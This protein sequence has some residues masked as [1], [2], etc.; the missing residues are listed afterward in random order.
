VVVQ[1]DKPIQINE[2]VFSYSDSKVI[3]AHVDQM[4]DES[5]ETVE[6]NELNSDVLWHMIASYPVVVSVDDL[7]N[8]IN[9]DSVNR[10][11][12]YQA[13]A[14]LRRIFDDKTHAASYIETVPKQGYRWLVEPLNRN[15]L[16]VEDS[17]EPISSFD[18]AIESDE[19]DNNQNNN[20][21]NSQNNNSALDTG[22]F[23]DL[24]F[25][26]QSIQTEKT[27]DSSSEEN[28]NVELIQHSL[29]NVVWWK[30][31]W[32]WASTL[33][34]T[35]A[36]IVVLM[37]LPKEP[38]MFIASDKLYVSPLT[39][40]ENSEDISPK[41]LSKMQW[42][43][44]QK[45][46]HLPAITVLPSVEPKLTPHINGTIEREKD[47]IKLILTVTPKQL[48]AEPQEVVLML[49]RDQENQIALNSQFNHLVTQLV[50]GT[51]VTTISHD[52]CTIDSFISAGKDTSG[53]CLAVIHEEYLTLEATLSDTSTS[54]ADRVL[55][56]KSI[57]KL[58]VDTIDKYNGHSIGYQI[59]ASY[60]LASDMFEKAHEQ[61][62]VAMEI[63]QNEPLI[64]KKLSESYRRL[65]KFN[66][67]IL[68][69]DALIERE[70]DK[71]YALYWKAYDLVALGYLNKGQKIIGENDIELKTLK[72]K[73]Y[74]FGINYN[75]LKS[76]ISHPEN[77]TAETLDF[78]DELI[79]ND[80]YCFVAKEIEDCIQEA[81]NNIHTDFHVSHWKAASL[82][83]TTKDADEAYKLV[84]N[85]PWLDE[86]KGNLASGEDR[87]FFIATFAHILIKIGKEK[88]A[89]ELLNRFIVFVNS[90]NSHHL[91]ALTL[92]EAY[93]VL[94]Q[95]QNALEQMAKL[96]AQG[97]LPNAKYQ[98]WPLKDNPN[99]DSIK[100]QWQF[101]NLLE[102]IEN[103]GKLIKLSVGDLRK[104][105]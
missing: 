16:N 36:V 103:R 42:W 45:L 102:L 63:N 76:V 33:L 68:L 91:Y 41:T 49:D 30:N 15:E 1:Q 46:Q 92:A 56:M 37:L 29:F 13:I 17:I 39:I 11:K 10:N 98:M 86:A 12:L 74:F 83:L 84:R 35:V 31:P 80:A 57:E 25:I 72:Q 44:N 65:G 6:L 81:E 75:Q 97:W 58:A 69:V 67:S 73:V 19:K 3:K 38:L 70:E 101:L 32:L 99:F 100:N 48:D 96:L 5:L 51:S 87:L 71:E 24:G 64:I 26:E 50:T 55:A 93:A 47:S 2:W 9:D 34:M 88:E 104:S 61:L 82:Y 95:R 90:S 62:L 79:D 85:D 78:I 40:S 53:Q 28:V 60:Y 21:D 23:N 22:I 105:Q 89:K 18:K 94:G 59:L 7:L 66:R 27:D 43:V 14:K 54:K 4:I 8:S 20:Q 77:H 52:V